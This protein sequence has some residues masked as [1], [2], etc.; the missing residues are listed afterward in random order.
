MVLLSWLPHLHVSLFS[1]T[2]HAL[3]AVPL[4]DACQTELSARQCG[5][6]ACR[7]GSGAHPNELDACQIELSAR[8]CELGAC[9]RGMDDP[10]PGSKAWQRVKAPWPPERSSSRDRRQR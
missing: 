5:L 7:R 9:R 2:R 6:D 1:S 8:Q 3:S 10:R 4:L